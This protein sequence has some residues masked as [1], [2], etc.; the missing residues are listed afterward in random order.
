MLK[1]K[2][3]LIFWIQNFFMSKH[4]SFKTLYKCAEIYIRTLYLTCQVFGGLKDDFWRLA[5]FV[6]KTQISPL[7]ETPLSRLSFMIIYLTHNRTQIFA[8]SQ[9]KIHL[10]WTST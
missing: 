7:I 4:N 8:S 3:K 5:N 2:K 10:N 6:T 9:N 1:G